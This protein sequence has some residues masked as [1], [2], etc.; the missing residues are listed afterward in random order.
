MKI[1]GS[2]LAL[3]AIT[4]FLLF[5]GI[6]FNFDTAILLAVVVII[7]GLFFTS[8]ACILDVV[9]AN[10]LTLSI[11]A[12]ILLIPLGLY[13]ALNKIKEDATSEIAEK[14]IALMSK[15]IERNLTEIG[16]KAYANSLFKKKKIPYVADKFGGVV[17]MYY[18]N[19]SLCKLWLDRIIV[20]VKGE[21][22]PATT[23]YTKEN[24]KILLEQ[25]ELKRFE[26]KNLK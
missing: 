6:Y 23:D 7:W 8:L 15:Y 18:L 5:L 24:E 11:S 26:E 17:C 2:L 20:E 4:A 3:L 21:T 10:F 25:E 16:D 14:K 1:F 19:S 22:S 13:G 9:G 12:F